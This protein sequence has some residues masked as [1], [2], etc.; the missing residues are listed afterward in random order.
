MAP[1]GK[2]NTN[3]FER[4]KLMKNYGSDMTFNELYPEEYYSKRLKSQSEI[5]R[6]KIVANAIYELFKPTSVIDFGCGVAMELMHLKNKG[7]EVLG[8]DKSTYAKKH[9][10]INEVTI[11]DLGNPVVVEKKFD[12]CFAFDFIEHILPEQESVV[13][14]NFISSSDVVLISS[15]WMVGDPLHFNEQP[16]EHWVEA[17]KNRGY[18]YDERATEHL[19]REMVGGRLWIVRN[20]QVFRKVA[21]Y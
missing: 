5:D 6:A 14:D 10:C 1:D 13:I 17:F 9:A 15:P 4:R 16:P 11:R 8:L 3:S 2:N 12:L 19:K 20:L 21:D 7:V 18:V